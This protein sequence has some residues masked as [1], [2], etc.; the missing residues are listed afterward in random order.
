LNAGIIGQYQTD[1]IKFESLKESIENATKDMNQPAQILNYRIEGDEVIFWAD[2]KVEALPGFSG[3]QIDGYRYFNK[4]QGWLNTIK[5]LR[6][7]EYEESVLNEIQAADEKYQEFKDRFEIIGT[8]ETEKS[9]PA[10]DGGF[11]N[12][13]LLPILTIIIGGVIF[14]IK[15]LRRSK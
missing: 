11:S 5:Y 13:T 14:L 10:K 12:V 9:L 15:K 3:I 4:E 1:K 7:S 2:K 8:T 6:K